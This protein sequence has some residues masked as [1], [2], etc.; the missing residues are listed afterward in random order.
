MG[1]LAHRH[2]ARL[3]GAKPRMLGCQAESNQSAIVAAGVKV[4]DMSGDFGLRD[5]A[6]YERYYGA[7]HPHPSCWDGFSS[8][9]CPS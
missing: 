4:V 8:M 5:A 3:G 9:A 6:A 2:G 7:K 1:R